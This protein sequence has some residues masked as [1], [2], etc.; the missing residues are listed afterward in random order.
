[1]VPCPASSWWKGEGREGRE[2]K[3][4]GRESEGEEKEE[5]RRQGTL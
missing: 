3:G 5:A 4:Q 2:G 1:M